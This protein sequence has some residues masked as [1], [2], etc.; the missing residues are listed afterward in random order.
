MQCV[1]IFIQMYSTSQPD[2]TRLGMALWQWTLHAYAKRKH[3]GLL[4]WQLNPVGI[5]I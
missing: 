1:K 3:G 5:S 4:T 2:P